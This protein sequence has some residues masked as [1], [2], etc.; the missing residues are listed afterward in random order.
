MLG[1]EQ[2][3]GPTPLDQRVG[4]TPVVRW[5]VSA[6]ADASKERHDSGNKPGRADQEHKR[7][8]DELEYVNY[9]SARIA[10]RADR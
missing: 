4:T 10:A 3:N 2:K 6:V 5:T 1:R 9:H 7:E 8:K